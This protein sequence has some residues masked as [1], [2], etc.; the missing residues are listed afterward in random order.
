MP[1]VLERLRDPA[2]FLLDDLAT[3]IE[4]IVIEL[5]VIELIELIVIG[6]MALRG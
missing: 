3:V 6:L 4:L 1:H 2:L 5:I